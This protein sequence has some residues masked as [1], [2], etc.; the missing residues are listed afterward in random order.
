MQN[1]NII[2]LASPLQEMGE[3]EALP[4]V[5]PNPEQAVTAESPVP[6]DDFKDSKVKSGRSILAKYAG[7]KAKALMG[8]SVDSPSPNQG[9]SKTSVQRNPEQA[10]GGASGK[11]TGNLREPNTKSAHSVQEADAVAD[12]KVPIGKGPESKDRN[13]ANGSDSDGPPEEL[14]AAKSESVAVPH[15]KVEASQR[16]KGPEAGQAKGPSSRTEKAAREVE[17]RLLKR[18][19]RPPTLLERL[20]KSE[21]SRERDELL[22]CVRF[23]CARNFLSKLL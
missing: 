10:G 19:K 6:T 16:T 12:A 11:P 7:A 3:V 8:I 5:E 4:E 21:I 13:N 20:L 22:Q 1:S 17:K 23:V 15:N 2:T 18:S 9:D 14:Q